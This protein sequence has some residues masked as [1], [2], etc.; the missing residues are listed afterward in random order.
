MNEKELPESLRGDNISEET[1]SLISSLSCNKD[2]LGKIY[3]YQGCW[4]YPNT[5]QGVLNFQKGFKPQETDIIIASFP[6]SGNTWL[7]ALTIALFERLNNTS[8]SDALHP[9]QSDNPHG[10]APFLET[11]LYLNSSTPDVTKFPSPRLFSTHMPL[12]TLQEPFKDSSP[13]KIVYVGVG[14]FGPIWEHILSYWRGSL[15][16]TKHVL[17]MRYEEMKSKPAAQVKRLAEF[18]GCP[19]TEEEEDQG[20][21][22][23]I[24]ELCSLRNLSG[25]E[26]NKTGKASNNMHPSIFFRKGE[27]GDFKNHLTP[28]ME[29]KIDMIVEEKYKGSG[30]KF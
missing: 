3:N 7:K 4:Y 19:F 8:S 11:I 25:L 26:I 23:K 29:N 12:H 2:F 16:D 9:L 14:Y 17:F 6:K 28:E 18:L 27:V 20:C 1:K 21:V 30:L 5:L 15:E 22:D 13:C 10:L 24:L